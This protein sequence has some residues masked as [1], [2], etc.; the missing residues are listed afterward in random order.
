[1]IVT[2]LDGSAS[3]IVTTNSVATS[4]PITITATFNGASVSTTLNVNA[5][6]ITKFQVDPSSVYGG[7]T[8][9]GTVSI[10]PAAGS[11]GADVRL[12][13]SAPATVPSSVHVA[14][15]A[16][17]ATFSIGTIGVSAKT[18][19]TLTA[20]V[21]MTNPQLATLI[22]LPPLLTNLTVSPS[23]VI[24]GV[25][26]AGS[27][28]ILGVA[29]VTGFVVT[30]TSDKPAAIPTKTVTIPAGQSTVSFDIA[31][32]GV[33]ADTACTITAASGGVSMQASLTV[34]TPNLVSLTLDNASV[35]GG[36]A[37]IV[38]GMLTLN[39]FGSSSGDK[40]VL[41]SSNPK[42]VTVPSTV[43][44][45]GGNVSASFIAVHALVTSQTQV[46][47]TASYGGVLRSATLTLNP[48]R[49]L[50]VSVTPNSI[51]GGA[52]ATGKVTLNAAPG[53]KSGAISIKLVSSA[54]YLVV[55]SSVTVPVGTSTTASFAV[56]S[57]AVTTTSYAS[58]TGT[59][60][61]DI[62]VEHVTVL[63]PVFSSLT[64]SPTTVKG[65]AGT[66]VTATIT[67]LGAAPSSGVVFT[68]LSSDTTIA[69]VP[70][71]VT[72]SGG[73]T[74]VTFTVAHKKVTSQSVVT[75]QATGIGTSK[76]AT[77]TVTPG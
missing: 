48:F 72:I 20:G 70:K 16:T 46:T 33:A 77:L 13:S 60:G 35:V 8:V 36:S 55:P 34:R 52:A 51:Y 42:L 49:F 76:S 31:T 32:I 47:I 18:S 24:G 9:T 69:T 68:L 45:L 14:A 63:S 75:I 10:S 61:S 65:S 30:V 40:V 57:K 66:T 73:K 1:M 74:T 4:T 71:T 5:F 53:S 37:A 25:K 38:N 54:A 7:N 44:V 28:S 6:Q 11:S 41:T 58:V 39:G 17:T 43:T 67:I 62:N 64:L 27:V 15:G 59:Y 50:S 21:G 3:F 56:T 22:V 2:G 12:G 23:S 19:V 26:S 29:P